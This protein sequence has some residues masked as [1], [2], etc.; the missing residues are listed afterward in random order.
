MIPKVRA[1]IDELSKNFSEQERQALAKRLNQEYQ[2]KGEEKLGLDYH[3]RIARAKA[4]VADITVPA[5]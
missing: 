4:A 2:G 3:N 5:E 1:S